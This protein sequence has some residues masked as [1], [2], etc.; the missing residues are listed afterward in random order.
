MSVH[1][2]VFSKMAAL[3][4][5]IT[6][7]TA[8]APSTP[9][10]TGPIHL[11]IW[12]IATEGDA[13]HKAWVDAV[14]TYN[15]KHRDIQI[16]I[17]YIEND[18]FKTQIQVA[19][20]AGNPP[21]IFQDWGGGV[22]QSY[23]KAGVVR[24]IQALSGNASQT[25]LPTALGPSTFGGKRYAIPADVAF[26]LFFY[27]K[28]LFAKYNVELPTTW[29]KFLAACQAFKAVGIVPAA[30]GNKSMW[31]GAFYTDYLINRIGGQDAYQ[32][33]V[34][35]QVHGGSF[36]DPVF[37]EA[38]AKLQEAVKAGCF[39]EGVN[40]SP[41]TDAG[42]LLTT[43]KAAMQLQG[44]WM[45]NYYR[46]IDNTFTDQHIDVLPFPAMEGGQGNPADLMGG[47]GQAMVVSAKAPPQAEQALMEIMSS[48]QFAQDQADAALLPAAAGYD[49]LF[50]ND[51]LATKMLH[52][53][54]ATPSLHLFYGT[55]ML[56]NLVTAYDD[57]SQQIFGLATT[58]EKAASDMQ[59]AAQK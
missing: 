14:S 55:D 49:Y 8:C 12:S 50:A 56:P 13:S 18:S 59:A 47:T 42:T 2:R 36:T 28:D 5:L 26:S 15:A 24:E 25:F 43:G 27:N 30:V 31:P 32:K 44:T 51:V 6:T 48:T 33:A 57:V 1:N 39:E 21:D 52:M 10:S 54:K 35:D 11:T 17:T 40:G 3:L 16:D 19:I 20:A 9:V 46:Q 58:P 29:T 22:L 38:F 37:V 23:I 4:V 7:V 45:L 41:E 34:Y 53:L